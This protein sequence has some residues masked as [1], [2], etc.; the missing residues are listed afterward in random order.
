MLTV[1]VNRTRDRGHALAHATHAWLDAGDGAPRVMAIDG[2][3][4][5]GK[6]SFAEALAEVTGVALVRG[7]DSTG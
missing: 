7:D 6:S 3:S 2:H 1:A 5:A 4:A